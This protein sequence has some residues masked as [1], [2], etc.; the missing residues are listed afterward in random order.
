M[1]LDHPRVIVIE[2]ACELNSQACSR[3]VDNIFCLSRKTNRW[4][5]METQTK[6]FKKQ[7]YMLLNVIS[8][9]SIINRRKDERAQENI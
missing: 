8:N 2:N 5:A 3:S 6:T 9:A 1:E 7:F 4:K